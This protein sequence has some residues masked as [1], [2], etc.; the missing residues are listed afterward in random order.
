[1]LREQFETDQDLSENRKWISALFSC[2][3]DFRRL[4]VEKIPAL[5]C[6]GMSKV[7]AAENT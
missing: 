3:S 1:M 2:A 5:A 7:D 4:A 6:R